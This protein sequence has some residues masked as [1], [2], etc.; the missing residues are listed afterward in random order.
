MLQVLYSLS[1]VL[2]YDLAASVSKAFTTDNTLL[3]L[4]VDGKPTYAS[5]QVVNTAATQADCC[6]VFSNTSP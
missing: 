2:L 6:N 1:L 4:G 5:G 3:S